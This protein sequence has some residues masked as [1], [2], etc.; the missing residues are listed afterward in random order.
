M[1]YYDVNWVK[2]NKLFYSILFYSKKSE[3]KNWMKMKMSRSHKE[4][5]GFNASVNV[6]YLRRVKIGKINF[7]HLLLSLSPIPPMP[8]A[9]VYTTS[10]GWPFCWLC[11]G[12]GARDHGPQQTGNP[13]G[14]D[15]QVQTNHISA[16]GG[17]GGGEGQQEKAERRQLYF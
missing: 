14:A 10:N 11:W 8:Q 7:N 3:K 16:W 5:T 13:G 1:R 9:R 15:L 17:A 6:N 4:W 12:R 2:E